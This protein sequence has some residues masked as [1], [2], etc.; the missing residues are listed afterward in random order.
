MVEKKTVYVAVGFRVDTS[1]SIFYFKEPDVIRFFEKL[2]NAVVDNNPD[3]V[4]LRM[5]KGVN[6]RW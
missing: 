3:F 2:R 1:R 6:Q 4:S 5:V